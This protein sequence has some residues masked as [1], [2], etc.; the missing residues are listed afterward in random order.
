M[1][2]VAPKAV[3]GLFGEQTRRNLVRNVIAWIV[4]VTAKFKQSY[5]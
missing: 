2:E 3:M 5:R 4:V 1:D